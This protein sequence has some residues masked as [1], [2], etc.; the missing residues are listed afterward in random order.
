MMTEK[1]MNCGGTEDVTD[2]VSGTERIVLC[3][4]CRYKLAANQMTIKQVGRPSLGVTKKVSLTLPESTWEHIDSEAN[5][6]RSEYFRK[7][8]DRDMWSQGDWSNNACLGYA[9]LGAKRL[10]YSEEQIKELIRAIYSEF[11]FKSIGEAR[12]EYER[13]PY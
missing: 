1:C 5:G 13:S 3:V 9:L 10:G 12:Q 8:L 6:N 2:F 7:L 4:N 11:D